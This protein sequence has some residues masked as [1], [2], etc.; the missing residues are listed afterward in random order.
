MAKVR[1]FKPEDIKRR[2]TTRRVMNKTSDIRSKM[3]SVNKYSLCGVSGLGFPGKISPVRSLMFSKHASQRVVLNHGEFPRIFTG[4]EDAY[5]K[6]SSF[7]V[8]AKNRLVLERKFVKFPNSPYSS[9]LY[10]FRDTVTNKYVCHLAE[11]VHWNV[12]KYGFQN[13]DMINGR[14]HESDII[15]QGEVISKTT[16]YDEDNHYC[17]GA[18]L[19]ILYTTLHDLTEDAIILSESACKKLEYSMVDKVTVDIS[20]KMFMLNNYG[21]ID[22]YKA[23][24]DIGEHIKS[25]ILC[26]LR[27]IS[28]LSSKSEAMIPHISDINYYTDGIITDIDIYSN[29]P[30]LQDKQLAYYH[31]C[32]MNWYN[33]IYSYVSTI[34]NHV[35]QDDTKLLD[36]YHKAKKY[37]MSNAKWSTKEKLPY[38]QIVFKILQKKQIRKGQK[39]TG[40]YGNKSVVSMILPDEC[41]PRD[42]FGRPVDMLANGFAPTNRII[43]F[44]LYEGTITFQME[45]I[46]NYIKNPNNNVS[47]D[48]AVQLVI[49]YMSLF[50]HDWGNSI[51]LKYRRNPQATYEDICNNGLY[52]LLPPFQEENVRDATI[53]AYD[54]WEE[55]LEEGTRK[56]S[57]KWERS[58][59]HKYTISTKLRHRWIEQK[60][61]KYAIGYQ[62]TWVLKQEASKNMS[63][64]ATGRTTLY[65]LPIKTSNYKNRKIQYS[66]NAIKFGEYDTYGFLQVVDVE[67]FGK[68][69][70]YYR[71]SQYEKNSLMMSHLND[72]AIPEGVVNQ[73]PQLE[74]FKAYL[75]AIGIKLENDFTVNSISTVDMEE[76]F[77]IANHEVKISGSYLRTILVMYSYYSQYKSW[78]KQNNKNNMYEGTVDM[79]VFCDNMI[80]KTDLFNNKNEEYMRT[81][82]QLFFKYL[83]ILDEEKFLK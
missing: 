41:M 82:F 24:P 55:R 70:T 31:N 68:M 20:E 35:D 58:I 78:L 29:A 44:A 53:E 4:A 6:R 61:E 47:R 83:R 77:Q 17:A 71:G 15:P 36:I 23:F 49:D 67:M 13:I 54:R 76:T 64:V 26:S 10:I 19:R 72:I 57:D 60:K 81:A 73:F 30:E 18:N 32:I 11:A 79:N 50:N 65:D 75:K 74:C 12:E 40:R 66:D 45:C 62:Y 43:G 42:E 1:Q 63:A 69:T 59:F 2:D 8:T 48:D 38:V 33:D 3:E 39:I 14:Y 56:A 27:E 21:T 80:T 5:G 7:F 52:M 25:G 51:K 22:N 34:I 16:S 9:I 46:H 37:L 28:A